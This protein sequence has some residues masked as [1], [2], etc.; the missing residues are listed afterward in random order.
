MNYEHI[1]EPSYII[2]KEDSKYLARNGK[3]G[4]IDYSGTDASS[5]IQSVFNALTAG[6]VFIKDMLDVSQPVQ[7]KAGIDLVGE[8]FVKSGFRALVAMPA[9]LD[10]STIGDFGFANFAHIRI[11][12]NNLADVGIQ[13]PSSQLRRRVH[14]SDVYVRRCVDTAA[15]LTYMDA[16]RLDY[17]IFDG[18]NVAGNDVMT[19]NGVVINNVNGKIIFT[20]CKFSSFAQYSVI[21]LGGMAVIDKCTFNSVTAPS[22]NHIKTAGAN[23]HLILTGEVWFE[24]WTEPQAPFIYG[25]PASRTFMLEI[26]AP[27]MRIATGT[28]P[29]VSGAFSVV[30][31]F[32]G[33]LIHDG[34]A[35]YSID[36]DITENLLVYGLRTNKPLNYT[37]VKYYNVLLAYQGTLQTNLEKTGS[38]TIAAGQT[39]VKVTHGLA[40]KPTRVFL[41]PTSDTGGKRFWVSSYDSDGDGLKFTITI[42][43]VHSN[44]ITFDYRGVV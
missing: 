31:I 13:G 43:S 25:D 39:A 2:F 37:N 41:S 17:V 8:S 42:D 9:V 32:G 27:R 11:D 10:L 21:L 20:N 22:Y 30:N 18:S 3:T 29:L 24:T 44:D 38:A 4:V 26:Y 12:G 7:L 28:Q 16:M 6:R 15:N 23:T 19:K 36:A 14:A 35:S 5:V 1:V 34:T 40:A 33:R